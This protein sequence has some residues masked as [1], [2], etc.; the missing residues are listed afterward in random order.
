MTSAHTFDKTFTTHP[1]GFA[2]AD[3]L[4]RKSEQ[5]VAI[6]DASL[7]CWK[8]EGGVLVSCSTQ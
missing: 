8:L 5:L 4:G 3:F 7:S 6:F 1:N 2:H